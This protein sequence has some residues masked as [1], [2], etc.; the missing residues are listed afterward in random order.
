MFSP[1]LSLKYQTWSR[2]LSDS[3][4]IIAISIYLHS[5]LCCKASDK[6]IS[7]LEHFLWTVRE[8]RC[9]QP[10]SFVPMSDFVV[11][12]HWSSKLANAVLESKFSAAFRSVNHFNW[13]V[14][15]SQGHF[16]QFDQTGYSTRPNTCE[17]L[18][19]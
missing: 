16:L 5:K 6:H 8:I 10:D 19:L 3:L 7:S 15:I 17:I 4:H 2:Q 13:V 11:T 14:D 1:W 18:S 9:F 12:S